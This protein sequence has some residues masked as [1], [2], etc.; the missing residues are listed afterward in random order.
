MVLHI[1]LPVIQWG[2]DRQITDQVTHGMDI[3]CYVISE[4]WVVST[5][6]M[7]SKKTYT[8]IQLKEFC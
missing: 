5:F 3:T 1:L 4:Q 2:K 6:R 7:C 8:E